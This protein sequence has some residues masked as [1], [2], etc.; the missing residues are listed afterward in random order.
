MERQELVEFNND[1]QLLRKRI[2]LIGDLGVVGER[3]IIA[4]VNSTF[5]SRLLEPDASGHNVPR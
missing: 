5:D 4:I 2:D 1:P 3:R